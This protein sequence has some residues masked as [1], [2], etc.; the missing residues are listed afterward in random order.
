[1]YLHCL[2]ICQA[3]NSYEDISGKIVADF[4]CGCGTLGIAS[5]LLGAEWVSLPY[6]FGLSKVKI[7]HTIATVPV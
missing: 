4:G 1:M 5:A 7:Q 3:E 6:N 2:K